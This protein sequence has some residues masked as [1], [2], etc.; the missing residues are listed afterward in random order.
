[1][2][3]WSCG[4]LVLTAKAAGDG[5][6]AILAGGGALP[7]IIASE[8]TAAGRSVHI[9]AIDGSFGEW[10][11]APCPMTPVGMGQVGRILDTLRRNGC[12]EM[13]IAGSVVRP[14]LGKL[15]LDFGAL[16]NLPRLTGIML[17]GD[18]HLLTTVVKFFEKRGIRVVGV[19]EVAPSLLA[20]E[21]ALGRVRPDA[22]DLR[23]IARGFEVARAIGALDI[24]Q[25]AVVDK[26]YVLAVEAA[27]GTDAL[28]ERVADLRRKRNRLVGRRR[29]VLVKR[30]KPGQDR[31]VDLPTIGPRTV[32]LAA[33]ANLAGIGVHAGGTILLEREQVFEIANAAGLFIVG[34]ADGEP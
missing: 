11:D 16:I 8:A 7:R 12:H 10:P 18:N 22:R 9:L 34:V 6:L 1:M 21:G 20:G 30:V 19:D 27:E 14:E 4:L 28:L 24:G 29:G 3:N 17:G 2:T 13:A 23:D 15:K 5:T 25:A 32:E 33:A 26:G 31:R